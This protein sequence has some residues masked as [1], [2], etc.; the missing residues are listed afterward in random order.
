MKS[1]LCFML[2]SFRGNHSGCFRG[3]RLDSKVGVEFL[4]RCL[5]KMRVWLRR[6]P[7]AMALQESRVTCNFRSRLCCFP[8]RTVVNGVDCLRSPNSSQPYMSWRFLKKKLIVGQFGT[9]DR[10]KGRLC[11]KFC[12]SS[13]FW[14]HCPC[15]LV[16]K[17]RA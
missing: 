10:W 9:K 14:Y 12:L 16:S 13:G 2:V 11:P 7:S 6:F 15:S 5:R 17:P 3:G 1:Y 4:R 8:C